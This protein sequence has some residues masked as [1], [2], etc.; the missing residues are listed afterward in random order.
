[1]SSEYL[2]EEATAFPL[3]LALEEVGFGLVDGLEMGDAIGDFGVVAIDREP[4]SFTEE[5]NSD[6]GSGEF[7]PLGSVFAKD[8]S[9]TSLVGLTALAF[10]FDSL[11]IG[12]EGRVVAS[13]ATEVATGWVARGGVGGVSLLARLDAIVFALEP[14]LDLFIE[15]AP[16]RVRTM[17]PGLR[18]KRNKHNKNKNQ[19]KEKDECKMTSNV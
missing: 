19:E 4:T 5:P 1:M 3:S 9:D 17:F 16:P 6:F 13:I 12:G 15:E 7:R 8:K 14:L 2:G 10:F 11:G 18:K